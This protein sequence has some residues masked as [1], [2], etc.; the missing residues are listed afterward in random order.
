MKASMVASLLLVALGGSLQAELVPGG[1][2]PRTD[3][4]AEFDVAGTPTSARSIECIDG[5]P[6]DADGACNG[7]CRFAVAVCLNQ[8][9]A[10]F[11]NCIPPTSLVRAAERGRR[12]V[13]LVFPSLSSSA[14]GAFVGVDTPIRRSGR[15]GRRIR[16][17]AVAPN[18]PRKDK[19][20]VLLVCR[21]PSGG[22]ATTTTTTTTTTSTTL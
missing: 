9:D 16:M 17:I 13:G 22:C 8:D 12:R 6:C 21:P 4:Y 2:S 14:C 10:A 5:D 15:L 18:R 19:D 11:P 3:C 1:G 20:S 7:M